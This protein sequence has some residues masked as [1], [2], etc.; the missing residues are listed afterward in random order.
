MGTRLSPSSRT[1]LAATVAL[2]FGGCFLGARLDV[3]LEFPGL[4]AA[5]IFVPY[6]IVTA[7]LLRT[8]TRRWWL[9]LL[10]ASAADFFPHRGGAF[11]VPFVL[12]AEIVNHLRAVLAAICL[13]RYGS[14]FGRLETMPEMVAYLAFAVF[15]VPAFTA[16][17][18]AALVAQFGSA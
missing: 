9:V 14:R 15:L 18:G 5:I 10:A 7:A 1:R 3:L 6:A 17:G 8:P 2:V 16:L 13:R 4:R 11:S 12:L